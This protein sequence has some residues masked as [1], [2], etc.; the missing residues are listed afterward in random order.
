MRE[1][2]LRQRVVETFKTLKAGPFGSSIASGDCMELVPVTCDCL[3]QPQHVDR[4]VRWRRIGEVGFARQVAVS[5]SS[6]RRWLA[7]LLNHQP[8]RILF[9]LRAP[10]GPLFGHIG[11]CTLDDAT[12]SMMIEAVVR[13]EPSAGSMRVAIEALGTWGRQL[14]LKELRLQVFSDNVPAVRLFAGAGMVPYGLTP[15]RKVEVPDGIEWI[16][17]VPGKMPER[18]FLHMRMPLEG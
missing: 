9:Y 17:C 6:T 15:L 2:E 16:D 13:G 10:G 7:R 11:L 5:E 14:G 12:A 8:D 18:F 3:D 1:E 4:L